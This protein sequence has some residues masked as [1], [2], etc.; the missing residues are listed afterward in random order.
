MTDNIKQIFLSNRILL[1]KLDQAI[2]Y[3]REEEYGKALP[4]VADTM[5][6]I[7]NMTDAVLTNRTYFNLVSTDSVL[8]ML[9]GIIEAQKNKDYVLLAD[10]LELQMASFICNVQELIINKEEFCVFD[11]ALDE[12]N[13]RRM[14]L[15]FTALTGKKDFQKE[16]NS[17]S[18]YLAGAI[19]S[20]DEELHPE[21]LLEEG[22][23]V[24]FAAC[25]EMTVG[26]S[27]REGRTIYLH[28]N[29][30]VAQEAFLL[31]EKWMEPGKKHYLVYGFGMGYVVRELLFLLPEDAEI[32]VFES[33]MNILKL[34]C[35]FS[36][37]RDWLEDAR[38]HVI[39]DPG[40]DFLSGRLQKLCTE[41]KVCIHYP[42]L[43]H[44]K[45]EDSR[46]MLLDFLPWARK[47]E[48]C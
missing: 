38:L 16:W 47:I 6:A 20:L 12:E 35:A 2:Y 34:A 4:I 10:L 48:Q 9:E 44:L 15:Q 39:Y 1:A 30:R 27:S 43:C 5:D 46:E 37:M 31:A 3:F 26:V 21:K 23:R 33:D 8:E 29:H 19:H 45:E 24:E 7:R 13:R 22:Y 42:S 14:R 18:D 41:D 25:G 36:D 17:K 40:C 32:E 28:T 11:G